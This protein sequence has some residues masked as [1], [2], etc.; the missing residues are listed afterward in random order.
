MKWLAI[1]GVLAIGCAK[2]EGT[3]TTATA[4]A[5]STSTA[6]ATSTSTA[7]SIPD[8]GAWLSF[9][10]YPG[11][12]EVCYQHITGNSMH[13]MWKMYATR[14]PVDRAREF[15]TRAHPDKLTGNTINAG[16]DNLAFH[17][18]SATGY[19]HC[20]REPDPDDQTVFIVSHATRR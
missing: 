16:D 15:Y 6:A 9:A 5:T 13:I 11:A 14:D 19:P 2:N 10:A 3:T 7:T 8:A 1:V 17:A 4:T 20:D 12:H 18:K